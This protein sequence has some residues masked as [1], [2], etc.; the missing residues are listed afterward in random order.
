MPEAYKAINLDDI[1]RS[2]SAFTPDP[3]RVHERWALIAVEEAMAAAR[4][5]NG[6]VGAV[7]IAPDGQEVGRAHNQVFKPYFR[8]DQH[9]E[10]NVITQFEDRCK[11]SGPSSGYILITSLE[12]CPM[13]IIRIAFAG[14]ARVHYLA[15]DPEGGVA[16]TLAGLPT[17]WARLARQVEF[18]EADC[19][20]V[21]KE[22]ASQLWLTTL[23]LRRVAMSQAS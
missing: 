22:M 7:L 19:S 21:L 13:C 8:S 10:M 6:A 17:V 14:I 23:K 12:P 16:E 3:M 5:G 2:L 15:P 18:S 20:P 9:A 4:A 11:N 1:V